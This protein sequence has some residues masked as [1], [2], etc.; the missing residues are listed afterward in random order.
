MNILIVEDDKS[1]LDF[2]QTSL[3]DEGFSVDISD[4]GK[5][6]IWKALSNDY[7]LLILDNN[8]PH[9]SGREICVELRAKGRDVPILM[10][11]VRSEIDTKVDLLR[12]GADDYMTKPFSF[13]E[14]LARIKAILRRPT[15][16]EPSVFELGD[17]LCDTGGRT[18]KCG[19][20]KILLT[21]KESVLLEFL[22]RNRGQFVSRTAI[23]E[24]VWDVNA[25]PFTNTV[26]VHIASL[27]RKLSRCKKSD[28]IHTMAGF[29]YKIE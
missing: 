5:I 16:I 25:D 24:H 26:E 8:L 14:L 17:M 29:G 3:S 28:A 13:A 21:L 19:R 2:L 27:R 4:D 15:R 20:K 12:A 1:I 23:L 11:S 7:D 9:K 10:L 18:V 6:G 22:L